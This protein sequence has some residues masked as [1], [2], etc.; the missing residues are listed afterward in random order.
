M[1]KCEWIVL[2]SLDL[3]V[4]ELTTFLIAWGLHSFVAEGLHSETVDVTFLD[5]FKARDG[6][7]SNLVEGVPAH[8]GGLQPDDL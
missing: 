1:G 5:V 3:D 7:L 4:Q 6:A 8:G 2:F